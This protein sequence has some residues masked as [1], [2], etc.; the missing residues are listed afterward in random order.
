M[1]SSSIYSSATLQRFSGIIW[2]D[3][4]PK[5]G[6]QPFSEVQT[7]LVEL[8]RNCIVIG[9]DIQKD[10][11]VISMDLSSHLLRLQGEAGRLTPVVFDMKVRDKQKCVRYQQYAVRGA[12][13]RQV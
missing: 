13:Q 9:H 11:L 5:N 12:Y 1:K 4:D 10:I 2:T 3:I 6:A 7:Q 8:L